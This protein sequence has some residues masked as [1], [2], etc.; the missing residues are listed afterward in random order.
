MCVEGYFHVPHDA[1]RTDPQDQWIFEHLAEYYCY[2]G[3]VYSSPRAEFNKHQRQ[4]SSFGYPS[5]AF[6]TARHCSPFVVCG[7][8]NCDNRAELFRKLWKLRMYGGRE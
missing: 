1:D 5:M 6:Y 7:L 8:L 3:T 4:A 2:R